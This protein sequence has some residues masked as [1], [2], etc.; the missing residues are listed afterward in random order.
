[1]IG[2]DKFSLSSLLGAC[3]VLAGMW[4]I[5]RES[6]TRKPIKQEGVVKAQLPQA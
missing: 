3:L 6:E 2:G 5:F 1:M 4:M